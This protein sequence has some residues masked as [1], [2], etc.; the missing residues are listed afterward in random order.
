M[1]LVMNS[2]NYVELPDIYNKLILGNFNYSIYK[3]SN[4]FHKT[5]IIN[6]CE[7]KFQSNN[8]NIVVYNLQLDDSLQQ[9]YS[10][11]KKIM[12]HCTKIMHFAKTNNY[13]IIVNCAAGI[14]RS[15]SA[16]VTFAISVGIPIETIVDYI[17]KRKEN[18]YGQ[19]WATLTNPLFVYYLKQLEKEKKD[20]CQHLFCNKTCHIK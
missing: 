10:Y 17:K 11:F 16:I 15:C 7:R 1:N 20:W 12:I 3:N 18:K 14:N 8:K 2:K 19:N 13:S 4:T 9:P 6:L 5:I